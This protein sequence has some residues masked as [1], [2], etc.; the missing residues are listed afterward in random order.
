MQM[1]NVPRHQWPQFLEGFSRRHRAWLATVEQ[2]GETIGRAGAAEAPL[3]SVTATR[4][5]PGI[6]AIEI[7]FAGDGHV[8]LTIENPATIRVRETGDGAESG[9]DIVDDEGVCTRVGFR[10]A[11]TPQMLDGGPPGEV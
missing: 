9:L 6:A 7:A 5:G 4:E 1:R 8:P 10:V 2:I 3:A 11:A